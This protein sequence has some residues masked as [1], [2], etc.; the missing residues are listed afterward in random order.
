MPWTAASFKS[1]HNHKLSSS[2]AASAA[3]V[4]N[5]I[6]KKTGDESRAI[7]IANSKFQGNSVQR[8]AH[9]RLVKGNK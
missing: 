1:K 9:R 7:R 6:L 3:N 8:A 4:A 5:A 2:Q